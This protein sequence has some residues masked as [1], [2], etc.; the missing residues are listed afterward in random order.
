MP[1]A[2]GFAALDD[3]LAGAV[4]KR[5]R[6]VT[7]FTNAS[8]HDRVAGDVWDLLAQDARVRKNWFQCCPA[9]S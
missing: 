6:A 7:G 9:S 1:A 3:A 8:R 5:R 4:E 2:S